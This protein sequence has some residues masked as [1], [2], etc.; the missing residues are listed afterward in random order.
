MTGVGELSVR[1]LEPGDLPGLLAHDFSPLV[2]ERDT[3][4][5]IVARDHGGVSAVA[6][7]DGKPAGFALGVRSADGKSVFLLQLHVRSELRRRGIG[8]RL[9]HEL[10]GRARSLGVERVWLLTTLARS[11]YEKRGYS[12]S[13]GVLD[14]EALRYVRRVKRS[15]VLSKRL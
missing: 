13:L 14:P 8:T 9:L 5:L 11:L 4:Y 7:L 2:T 3:I 12:S 10:E 6:E 15:L 1:G